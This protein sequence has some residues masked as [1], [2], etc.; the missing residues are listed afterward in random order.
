MAP[1]AA[2]EGQF[3][4]ELRPAMIDD[5]AIVAAGLL[6][7]G[8]GEPTLPGSA[9]TDQGRIEGN[10]WP[11]A[12]FLM[13]LTNAMPG[14]TSFRVRGRSEFRDGLSAEREA[15]GGPVTEIVP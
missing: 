9:R 12:L 6:A 5:G 4:A 7:N 11:K 13:I 3:L 14:V 1:I 2:R 8:A 15:F 10:P